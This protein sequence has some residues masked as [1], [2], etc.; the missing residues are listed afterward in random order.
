MAAGVLI[1]FRAGSAG[2]KSVLGEVTL[3]SGAGTLTTPLTNVEYCFL[4]QK[5]ATAVADGVSWSA[6]GGTIT[7]DSSN[8][9]SAETYSVLA[10][11]Y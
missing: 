2:K 6:S 10:F 1:N 5:D 3:S 4:T 8:A 9:S 11:G 7:I